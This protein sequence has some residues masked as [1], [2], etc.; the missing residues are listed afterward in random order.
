MTGGLLAQILSLREGACVALPGCMVRWDRTGGALIVTDAPRRG[1]AEAAWAFARAQKLALLVRDGL[2]F[3]D[4]APA[5][6]GE[7]AQEYA[8]GDGPWQPAWFEA[9]ALLASILRRPTHCPDTADV[10]LARAAAVACAQGEASFR[11]FLDTLRQADAGALRAGRRGATRPAAAL[12]AQWLHMRGVG[13]P[14][15]T[16]VQAKAPPDDGASA[17]VAYFPSN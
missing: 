16:F 5:M 1:M 7:A 4:I 17:H 11:M 8:P 15:Q 14:V 9:Q 3:F 6:Y 13:L 12:C 2:V 10:A